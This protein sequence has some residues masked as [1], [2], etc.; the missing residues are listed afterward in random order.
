MA[1]DPAARIRIDMHLHTRRSFDSLNEPDAVLRTARERGI[2]CICVTDHNRIEAALELRQ[3]FPGQVIV[4]EE[5]KTAEGVD[6]IGLYLREAI[7]RGTPALETCSRIHDQGG[8]VYMPH[9]YAPGKGG[10]GRLLDTIAAQVDAIEGFN[11]RIHDP[12]L[13]ERAVEWGREH[14]VPVGAGSDAHTLREIGRAFVEAAA[15]DDSPAGLLRALRSGT[16][17]GVASSRAVHLASTFAKVRK[18]FPG[19]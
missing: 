13:N 5:V 6:I 4:G 10:D 2:G 8:I 18:L 3:R 11:A 14:D 9:P 19:A 15:F 7:P 17:H 1:G 16:I 12:A